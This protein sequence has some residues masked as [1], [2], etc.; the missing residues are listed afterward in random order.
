MMRVYLVYAGL[1]FGLLCIA[2]ANGALRDLVYGPAMS[3]LGAHQISTLTGCSAFL[4]YT[5]LVGKRWPI[6]NKIV[7]LKVGIM[8]LA[9]TLVFETWMIV[10]L[11][12]KPFSA[13]LQSYDICAGQLWV[14]VLLTALLSPLVVV[15]IRK[16][17]T[18]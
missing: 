7:A 11:Q 2:I 8:W 15:Q 12:G 6:A 3:E 1:W 4:A 14:L 16:Q 10:V 9:M 13:V 17:Q 18:G 5:W